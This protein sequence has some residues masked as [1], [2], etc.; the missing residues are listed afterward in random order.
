MSSAD[1]PKATGSRKEAEDGS[2]TGPA[3]GGSS[4][5]SFVLFFSLS[6]CPSSALFIYFLFHFLFLLVDDLECL[7]GQLPMD[8]ERNRGA[9]GLGRRGHVQ[10]ADRR[11]RGYKGNLDGEEGGGTAGGV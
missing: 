4:I 1:V 10:V 5:S 11:L 8:G 2:G 6:F 3:R 9:V 7:H